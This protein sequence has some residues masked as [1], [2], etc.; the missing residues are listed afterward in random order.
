M[1][2]IGTPLQYTKDGLS[3]SL[4][5]N[6]DNRIKMIDN[7]I[8]LIVFTPKGSFVADPDF[9]FEYWN[10]EYSNIHYRNFNNGHTGFTMGGLY[11]DVT[12]K[13]CQDS[14]R[15][16]IETYDNQLK[17]I[18]VSIELNGIDHTKA[19]GK[20]SIFSKYEVVVKVTGML[21]DGLGVYKPY[22]KL[23]SFYMEP[24]VKKLTI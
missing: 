1:D 8:E 3:I 11:N 12:R 6:L 9:G 10:H 14:I 15:K 22:E 13:E 18:D 5:R 24:T 23:I 19:K 20:K 4:E 21:D 16:S 7:F 2:Y 17:Q